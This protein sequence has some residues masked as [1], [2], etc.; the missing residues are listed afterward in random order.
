MKKPNEKSSTTSSH[1]SRVLQ[2]Y[3][4]A[5]VVTTSSKTFRNN[6]I[7]LKPTP[8]R[9]AAPH[10]GPGAPPHR[11]RARPPTTGNHRFCDDFAPKRVKFR[12][13]L[14]YI[15]VLWGQPCGWC[16]YFGCV[17]GSFGSFSIELSKPN[18]IFLNFHL[19]FMV[20][21]KILLSET[22]SAPDTRKV[23]KI[24]RNFHQ[25]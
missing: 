7:V 25:K 9:F 5:R 6:W 21:L 15:F 20:F 17:F 23:S 4:Q 3:S 16:R 8:S 1:I 19:F 24:A 18:I 2:T 13:N 14:S 12:K 10:N 11:S 22:K